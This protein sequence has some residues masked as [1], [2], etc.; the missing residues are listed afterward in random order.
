MSSLDRLSLNGNVWM[1]EERECGRRAHGC[2]EERDVVRSYKCIG[3]TVWE[4]EVLQ[5]EEGGRKEMDRA[6]SLLNSS[7]RLSFLFG[8]K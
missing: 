2:R 6:A 5:R 7:R 3:S 4:G 1:R 8:R